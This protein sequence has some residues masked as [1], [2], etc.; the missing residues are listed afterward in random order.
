MPTDPHPD[1]SPS[2][3]GEELPTRFDSTSQHSTPGPA[4][5]P[6]GGDVVLTAGARPLPEYELV[7]RLGRG[8]FGEVWL[9]RGP[10]GFEV[11]LKFVRLGEKAGAVELRALE[12]MKGIRHANL[13][14]M[15]GAWQ[16]DDLLIVAM[17]RADRT[18]LDRLHEA[19]EQGQPGI[20][21]DELLEYMSDAARGLDHLN[22]FR[23]PAG[24][25]TATGIQHKDVKPQNLLLVGGT[26]KVADFGL[27]KVLERTVTSASGGLTPAYAAPE[28]L[29]GRTTRWSDQYALALTYCQLRS[30]R[31]P[32]EGSHV[33]IM[34]GHA[35]RPPDLTMLPEAERAAVARALAKEPAHRWPSCRDFVAA[36]QVAATGRAAPPTPARSGPAPATGG[37]PRAG[38]DRVL[39][40]P[41]VVAAGLL[42][43]VAVVVLLLVVESRPAPAT[44][45]TPQTLR[46]AQR[47]GPGPTP[48]RT[49]PEMLDCTGPDGVNAADVRRAQQA[50][51]RYLGRAVEETVELSPGVTMTFVLVPPGKFRMGSPEGEPGHRGDERLHTVTLTT[52]FDLART[53]LTRSQYQALTRKDP[54]H[55][56]GDDRPV[57]QVSWEEA[58]DYAA[59]LTKQL[60]DRQVYRL[61]TEAEWEYAC[62]AGRP[63]SM[64]F[65]VGDGRSLSSDEANCNGNRPYGSAAKGKYLE[66]TWR[67]GSYPANALGLYDMHGNVWEWC[68]DRYAPYPRGEATNPTGPAEGPFRVIRGGSWSVSAEDCRSAHR[69]R[70][71]PDSRSDDTG[72]RLARTV[73]Y[74]V[75]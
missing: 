43:V 75:P 71:A 27:A 50:W 8:G 54:S 36:L 61:P 15:F 20:P 39:V 37:A 62:L 5:A 25:S 30:A 59:R 11:A 47:P 51:A 49:P 16:R 18:L 48:A 45:D 44:P 3:T 64:T 21:R 9:A 65:G 19:L 60:G 35:L 74:A 72:F 63:P 53:E 32:F 7:Q 73:P 52:P 17:E 29:Q 55:F 24:S 2:L 4:A 66:S 69:G 70:R 58:Q 26:V 23:D 6:G 40:W 67:V 13:L 1:E 14:P 56:Q 42:A 38:D 34:A 68:A 10:G 28:F 22:N 57:E 46:S 41:W 12:L 33:E 31:L